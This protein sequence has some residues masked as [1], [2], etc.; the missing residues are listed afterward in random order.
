MPNFDEDGEDV[1]T[2]CPW[3]GASNWNPYAGCA[4]RACRAQ[5]TRAEAEANERAGQMLVRALTL[6]TPDPRA[7]AFGAHLDDVL[8]K[9]HGHQLDD[10]F[11]DDF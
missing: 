7:T 11:D 6:R 8:L 10:L 4:R 2:C 9:H 3:C 1:Q 5:R